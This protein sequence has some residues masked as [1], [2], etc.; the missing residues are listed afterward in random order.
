MEQSTDV[1][2]TRQQGTRTEV[3]TVLSDDQRTA[4][5]SFYESARRNH[6]LEP[7]VT[8]MV[9]LAAA[10]ALGCSP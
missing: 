4:Y 9:H 6:T 10:M 8:L 2:T 7:R 1:E 5:R 3:D